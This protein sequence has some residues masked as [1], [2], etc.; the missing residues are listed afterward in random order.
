[1]R[2]ESGDGFLGDLGRRISDVRK[3]EQDLRAARYSEP[4]PAVSWS[5]LAVSPTVVGQS[6]CPFRALSAISPRV[7]ASASTKAFSAARLKRL[8]GFGEQIPAL[9]LF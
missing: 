2:R 6:K 7:A 1:M 8:S 5:S 3:A 4:R 9:R